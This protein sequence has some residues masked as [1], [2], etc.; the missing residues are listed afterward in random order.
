MLADGPGTSASVPGNSLPVSVLARFARVR[1]EALFLN[2]VRPNR[3]EPRVKKRRP[4]AFPF[5]TK[6]WYVLRQ[7]LRQ[8]ALELN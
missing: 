8:H 3:G 6:P 5:T 4:K 1:L 2:P 7:A